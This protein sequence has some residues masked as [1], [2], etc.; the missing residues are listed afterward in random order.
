M[1][2]VFLTT[3]REGLEAFLI[4]SVAMA[5]LRKT[6]NQVLMAPLAVGAVLGILLS[7]IFGVMLVHGGGLSP[8]WEAWFALAAAIFVISCIVPIAI[9]GKKVA[10]EIHQKLINITGKPSIAAWI[11]MLLFAVFMVG[12]EAMEAVMIIVALTSSTQ[13]LTILNSA[14]LGVL[15]AAILA[16]LWTIFGSRINVGLLFR[17]TGIFLLLFALQLIVY[18]FHEFSEADMVPWIDNLYWHG[19]TEP[20]SPDGKYGVWL[21]YSLLLI[22]VGLLI[23]NLL[24]KRFNV[25]PE[26]LNAK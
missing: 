9:Y 12:R 3:F 22:P 20:F 11:G 2:P 5:F 18:A 14:I 6:N 24:V 16:L 4:I 7:G 8:V 23:W 17:I 1:F 13:A 19:L 21:T 25:T 26:D 10:N 15:L